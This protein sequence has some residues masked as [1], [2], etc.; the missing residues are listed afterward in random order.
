MA[1]VPVPHTFVAGDDAT[2]AVMQT[3]TDAILYLL[4]S[5]TSSGSRRPFAL[6]RQTVSQSLATS[7][8]WTALTFDAEDVDY[9]NGHST[10]TNTDRYTAGTTGWHHAPGGAGFGGNA[11]GRR[12]ARLAVNGTALNA[13]ATNTTANASAII[14]ATRTIPVFLNAGDILRVEALQDS[15]G[16][17]STAAAV[18]Q[19]SSLHVEWRS[20]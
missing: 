17:L 5:T 18:E 1:A 19:Q 13:S 3:L 4:G 2:S 11:T 14:V 7:G 20:N 16:A 8:T 15:G 6:L 10:V 9:D 12:Q